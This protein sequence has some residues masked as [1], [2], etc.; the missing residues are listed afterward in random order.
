MNSKECCIELPELLQYLPHR[1]P[2]LFV[3]KVIEF[4][5]AKGLT[6]IKNVT[7]NEPY[8]AG[9][10]PHVPVMP[11]V[12]MIEALGQA[13]TIFAYRCMKEKLSD[14]VMYYFAG[15]NKARFKRIVR[16]GDQLILRID[17]VK[18]RHNIWI[19]EAKASVGEEIACVAELMSVRQEGKSIHERF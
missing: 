14:Q 2:F 6:A 12:V 1:P 15:I 8:F 11:G 19:V 13:A 7:I 16:P 5:Y 3:D 10:F 9:H 17:L 4:E 18:V